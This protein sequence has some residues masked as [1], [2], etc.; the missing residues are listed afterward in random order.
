MFDLL[1]RGGTVIDGTG[2]P[3]FRADVAVHGKRIAAIGDL[4]R[5]AAQRV[6]DATGLTVCP[7]FIDTH[8]H[9][10]AAL[11]NDPQHESGVSMGVTTEVL[12]QDGLSYAPLSQSDYRNYSRY[13]SG[14]CGPAPPDLDMSSMTAFRSHYHHKCAVN[15]VALVPHC[16]V[17]LSTVG[18]RDVPLAGPDLEAAK[19]IVRDGIEQGAAGFSTGLGFFPAAY[20]NTAELIELA[21]VVA[22]LDGVFVIQ[23]RFFNLERAFGGGGAKEVAEIGL[24]SG[25]KIHLAHWRTGPETAGEVAGLMAEIDLAKSRGLDITL[26]VY[27]YPCGSTMPV[28]RLPGRFVEGGPDAILER[29][30]DAETR[31]E[32]VAYLEAQYGDSVG[33][34][35]WTYVGSEKNKW[36]EGM[37]YRD[38]A[39]VLGLS[40]AEMMCRIMLEEGLECALLVAPPRSTRLWRQVEADE[41]ALLSRPDYTVGSDSIPIGSACHPRAYGAFPRFLGRLRRR[42]GVPL[43]QLIQRM[44]QNA[45][46][47]FGL[48]GR[49]VVREGYVA[50]VVAFDRDRI[51][52]AASFEDPRVPAAGID[53]VMVN[54]QVT[55]DRGRCTETLAGEAVP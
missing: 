35:V 10:D 3:G 12:C 4:S 7:G 8:V 34:W 11:L 33:E 9:T 42:H 41:M 47:R 5:A 20:A 18:F 1:I 2:E 30:A 39:G 32:I 22:E 40:P 36:L 50:D 25:A 31:A 55:V 38:A 27:P 54:G 53:Y 49:G 45:A 44:T 37:S 48:T 16:A 17:R 15:T 6:I 29:L 28:C 52:D 13:L 19:R 26:D 21:R 14:L 24:Q 51:V 23:H 46:R 43:E